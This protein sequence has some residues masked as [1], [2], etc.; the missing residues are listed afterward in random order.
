MNSYYGR[1]FHFD[2]WA[3]LEVIASLTSCPE[4]P[5]KA[6]ALLSHYL[7]EQWVA[8]KLLTTGQSTNRNDIVELSFELCQ[9]EIPKLFA[10]W[11]GYLANKPDEH[12]ETSFTY[13]NA[14][15]KST[16]RVV[17][18]LLTDIVDHGTYHRG[19]IATH[20]RAAGGEPA[21]T[22]FTRWVKETH[23][24]TV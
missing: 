3:N 10:A 19:Q 9:V 15:G 13:I 16:E 14:V 1:L 6:V 5:H 17:S 8:H 12:F 2:H 11:R 23:R 22:W 24:G 21:K 7:Q 18:D 4:T 20:V